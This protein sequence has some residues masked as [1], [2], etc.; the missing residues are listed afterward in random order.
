MKSI[1]DAVTRMFEPSH[2][3]E[4]A[5]LLLELAE[6]GIA[7]AAHF[8]ETSGQDLNGIIEFE[9]KG[10]AIVERIHELLDN[11]FILRFD[12]PE[13]MRLT[14]DLDNIIDGMR[15]IAIHIDIYQPHLTELRPD[16][17][18][19][20]AVGERM[21]S[22]VGTLVA[23]LGEPRLSLQRVREVA[24]AIDVDESLADKLVGDAE[25]Q[26]VVEYSPPG[27]NRLQFIAWRKLYELLE[28]MTDDANHC[29]KLVLSLA[30]KEA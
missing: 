16:A 13:A 7:C 27:A 3:E 12:I 21:I 29:A 2:N 26:L 14:D 30:R 6:T 20:L 25:R 18:D 24:H 17:Q 9:H 8:K 11:S 23:M 5:R 22:G 15:K 1:W 28:E 4:F 19:L 10:D